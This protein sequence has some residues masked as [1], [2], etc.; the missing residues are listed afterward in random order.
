MTKPTGSGQLPFKRVNS[1][2]SDSGYSSS[3]SAPHREVY[4]SNGDGCA[5]VSS[6]TSTVRPCRP[7]WDP[8][9]T[10]P[11]QYTRDGRQLPPGWIPTSAAHA[12]STYAAP[13]GHRPDPFSA[14]PPQVTSDGHELP[15]GW[16]ESSHEPDLTS[17]SK[18]FHHEPVFEW[19]KLILT[20]LLPSPRTPEADWTVPISSFSS[21]KEPVIRLSTADLDPH[22][23]T[24]QLKLSD[25][26]CPSVQFDPATLQYK[27]TMNT[28]P[29]TRFLSALTLSDSSR[30]QHYLRAEVQGYKI[31]GGETTSI[32]WSLR[33]RAASSKTPAF[34]QGL[35][36]SEK[37]LCVPVLTIDWNA[38]DPTVYFIDPLTSRHDLRSLNLSFF[39]LY[40]LS[41]SSVGQI[42]TVKTDRRAVQR[43]DLERWQYGY[44]PHLLYLNFDGQAKSKMSLV[45][46]GLTT[47]RALGTR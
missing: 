9:A 10:P 12:T 36:A 20:S 30:S 37:R 26:Y 24:Q 44:R 21:T 35:R 43:N 46:V 32:T 17:T 14:R 25:L 41:T 16:M 29:A 15:P 18:H 23:S 13:P 28:I 45:V 7:Q 47:F 3:S 42:Q 31:S 5:R 38:S 33:L 39:A 1:G 6:L 27:A 19:C 22:V 11:P 34:P 4:P 40:H 2:F 8:F